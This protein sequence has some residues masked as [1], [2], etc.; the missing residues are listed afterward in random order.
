MIKNLTKLVHDLAATSGHVCC[1]ARCRH[2]DEWRAIQA[3]RESVNT[4][5]MVR[6]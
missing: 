4:K 5:R 6:P 2:C 3:I 1:G